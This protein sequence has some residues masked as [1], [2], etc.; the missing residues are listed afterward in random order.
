[1]ESWQELK[2]ETIRL[3]ASDAVIIPVNRI[4]VEDEVRELCK[5][6]LC[7]GY[8]Q[9]AHCPP[10]TIK[11]HEFR[12][13]LEGYTNAIVFKMDIPTERLLSQNRFD[14]FRKIYVIATRI[15][16]LAQKIGFE[17]ARGFVAGS[18]KPVFC[19]EAPCRVLLKGELCSNPNLARPSMEA[20]GINVFRVMERVGWEIHRI[21][22]R[23]VARNT[24][25][26]VLVGLVLID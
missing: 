16:S 19:P 12:E 21:T 9:S 11:P 6:P 2:T 5:K 26:G 24:A 4:P 18:C 8:G 22:D 20:V 23:N 1:M 14:E 15:E 13:M 25:K 3:G 7:K 10:Q 17:R